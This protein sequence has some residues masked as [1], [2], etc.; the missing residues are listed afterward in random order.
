MKKVG[1]VTVLFNSDDVLPG[2]FESLAKQINAEF[3]LYVIDNSKTR[4]GSDISE[5]LA[6]NYGINAKVVFNNANY[7]VAKGNNQGIEMAL[8][9]NCDYVLLANN[10]IEFHDELM[11]SKM[12]ARLERGNEF[13]L[14]PK[15]YYYGGS[16][17]WF[18]GGKFSVI[19]ATT[20][21]FWDYQEDVGQYG[22]AMT[23]EYAPTCFMLLKKDVFG[24]VGVMDEKYFVYY[25]DSD[26]AWRLNSN[27]IKI[28]FD[29]DSIV[30]HKVSHST[31][32]GVSEFS[33][34]YGLRNRLYFIRK[35]Y[36]WFMRVLSTVYTV[37]S[38]CVK[39]A[40]HSGGK[41]KSIVKGFVDGFGLR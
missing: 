29:K 6:R 26:F 37:L 33:L 39:F 28:G 23:T 30:L 3:I 35:N 16:R 27:G 20:P 32:G 11:M 7:G 24:K 12:I 21:H 36:G 17:I 31:G 41:R 25:D 14:V 5:S 4:S 2:F 22:D 40:V 38:G 13:V 1:I 8:V 10:D 18:A 15:I 34:Y 19:K 9:D